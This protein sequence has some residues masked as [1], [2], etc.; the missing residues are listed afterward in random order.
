M[1]ILNIRTDASVSTG[2]NDIRSGSVENFMLSLMELA[3]EDPTSVPSN[4]GR[5]GSP[6]P[7]LTR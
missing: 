7:A 1:P 5:P 4:I 3:A 6:T 2:H